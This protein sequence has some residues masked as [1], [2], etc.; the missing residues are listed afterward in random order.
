MVGLQLG[1]FMAGAVV[2]ETV[3]SWPGL[4]QLN[5]QAVGNRDYA[6]VQSTLLVTAA[7]IA[8]INLLVDIINS[9]IDPRITLE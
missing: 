6:L 2:V 8:V 9:L 7:I 4:G 3:F 5:F 1:I